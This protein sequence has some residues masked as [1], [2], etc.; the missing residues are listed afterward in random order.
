MKFS[1][2][3]TE[4]FGIDISD[5]SLKIVKVNS[6]F[7]LVSFAENSVAPKVC[8]KGEIQEENALAKDIREILLKVKGEE[9]NTKRVICSLPEEKC[10]LDILRIPSVT[11]EEIESVVMREAEGSIPFPLLEVYFD[12]EKIVAATGKSHIKKFW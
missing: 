8:K 12:F 11:D 9:L 4:S 3:E 7:E 2:E 5:L 6:S 10:F 1:F